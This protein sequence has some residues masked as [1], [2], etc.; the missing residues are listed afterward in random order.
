MGSVMKR[1]TCLLLFVSLCTFATFA[2]D[3]KDKDHPHHED[4]T[5]TQLGT[6]HFPISCAASVQKPFARGVAL[7]HSFW[8]EE[9]EK[10][11][12]QIAKDDPACAMAHWGVAMSL[13]HQLWNEP[14]AKVIARGL[15]EVNTAKKLGK[16]ATAR[17]KAYID[18]IASAGADAV[19]FQ[20][21]IAEAESTRSEPWRV[22]F[23]YQDES[24]Y[25][26]WK[27]M[28]FTEPQWM[29]L[30]RHAEE[31]GL[32]FISSP[33][34]VEAAEML[35][36]I[37]VRTWKVASGEV[38]NSHLFD[39]LIETR[40]PIILS[41]GFSSI[42]EIDFTGAQILIETIAFWK[43]RGLD[44]YVARLESQRAQ[45]TLEKYGIV[46][47]LGFGQTFHSV[48]EAIRRIGGA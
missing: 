6:V 36:R 29:G 10:E 41:T 11:F 42:V 44:F 12:L 14:D 47:L 38:T 13:W 18:A 21:H 26:Y 27:R 34:S 1:L 7:L 4:L 8:Y 39:Y 32:E 37:G 45:Q 40:L 19:K 33:F 23:S 46:P 30:K 43:D 15:D 28:E 5:E 48:D 9:A 16:K 25:A 2:D 35:S 20:T 24:R 31:R 17:E 22:P 3:D